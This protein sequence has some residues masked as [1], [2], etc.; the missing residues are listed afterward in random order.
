MVIEFENEKKGLLFYTGTY[1]VEKCNDEVVPIIYLKGRKINLVESN[2]YKKIFYTDYDKKLFE[3]LTEKFGDRAEIKEKIIANKHVIKVTGVDEEIT[4]SIGEYVK[5]RGGKTYEVLFGGVKYFTVKSFR[6]YFYIEEKDLQKFQDLMN[7]FLFSEINPEE[8]P[9]YR[10]KTLPYKAKNGNFIKIVMT[11]PRKISKVRDYL[12]ENGVKTYEADVAFVQRYLIDKS[13]TI[14]KPLPKDIIYYDI[15]VLP[16]G[17]SV[18]D[19]QKAPQPIITIAYY[20]GDGKRGVYILPNDV[21]DEDR[22]KLEEIKILKHFFG[23]IDRK[24]KGRPDHFTTIAGW[25]SLLFDWPYLINRAKRLNYWLTGYVAR[26]LGYHLYETYV[27]TI[28]KI[29]FENAPFKWK[30]AGQRGEDHRYVFYTYSKDDEKI[31]EKYIEEN[32]EDQL[33]DIKSYRAR[34]YDQKIRRIKEDKLYK[35]YHIELPLAVTNVDVMLLYK[36]FVNDKLPTYKLDE[37]A[38][39]EGFEGKVPIDIGKLEEIWKTNPELLIEYNLHDS[40]LVYKIDEK[41]GLIRQLYSLSEVTS[42]IT[43]HV[44]T[45]KTPVSAKQLIDALLLK[46]AKENGIVL[47][48][49]KDRG[50]DDG[51]KY[52]GAYVHDPAKG[53]HQWVG[54]LDFNSLYPTIIRAF[55][56]SPETWVPEGEYDPNMHIKAAN[57]YFLREPI[58]LLVQAVNVLF[59]M[60]MSIKRQLGEYAKKY[61]T[62]STEY[63]ALKAR[64]QAVKGVLNSVY[65]VTGYKK[66]RLYKKEVAEN[67]TTIG[68]MVW[69]KTKE[70]AEELGYKV[71]Y[72]D[73]VAKDSRIIIRRNGKIEVI[74]IEDLFDGEPDH[75]ADDGR[76]YKNLEGVEALTLDENIKVTW[77]PIKYVMRHRTNKKMYRLWL[78]NT[79]HIDVTED[80][81]V[82]VYLNTRKGGPKIIEKTVKN[83]NEKDTL[84]ILNSVPEEKFNTNDTAIKYW[85]LIGLLVGD[86]T[87]NWKGNKYYLQL[88]T[89]NDTQEIIEKVLKPLKKA[90][91]IRNYYIKNNKGD[92]TILSKSLTT[93]M[94][95]FFINENNKKIIPELIDNLPTAYK[96]AFLRGYFTADGTIIARKNG[97]IIRLTTIS[98]DLARRVQEVLFLTGIASTIFRESTPNKYNGKSSGTYSYHV[99]IK[100]KEKFMETIRFILD[101]KND[102]Y[103]RHQKPNKKFKNFKDKDVLPIT[104][105]KIEEIQYKDYVYDI[106]VG[107]TH[108]FFANG[109]LVHNTDSQYYV[110]KSK[111]PEEAVKELEWLAETL[112]KKVQEWVTEEF[113]ARGEYFE[114]DPD[115]IFQVVGFIAKKNYVGYVVY[116]DG[117]ILEEPDLIYAGLLSRGDVSDAVKKFLMDVIDAILLGG[118]DPWEVIEKWKQ[119]V[120]EGK[121]DNDVV[122]WKS[123]NKNPNSYKSIQPHVRAYRMLI[124]RGV[125]PLELT[126]VGFVKVGPRKT[127][128][129]AL[130]PGDTITLSQTQRQYVWKN[131]FEKKIDVIAPILPPK[132]EKKKQRTLF[133]FTSK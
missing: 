76:E 110:L 86:G 79:Q 70:F 91:A 113:G 48:T 26:K 44:H 13:F 28:D 102:T 57:G 30:Y 96:R 31:I 61:G 25:N 41:R 87:W 24:T 16:A 56:I 62:N 111:T 120:L 68:R 63:R 69:H 128:L 52:S 88:S 34:D 53:V 129:I 71:V 126:K 82:F 132:K 18:P 133:D 93:L 116:K 118:R 64:Y 38:K 17:G 20:T 107:G 33:V 108:K 78:T 121:W 36:K 109:I 73:S 119:E 21:E 58:G 81:S 14:M 10:F 89:G 105:K 35:K 37:I 130:A 6:P 59:D 94:R 45:D 83:I 99:N 104:I 74:N 123:L 95:K 65:G 97:T 90:G 106:E 72:G 4:K 19:P 39:L 55:N 50:E 98:P 7:R 3:E 47:P 22:L 66:F 124:Q 75:V 122:I 77:A 125:N 46:I 1:R 131:Q 101:R 51:E 29:E 112:T 27:Y 115:E 43:D 103:Y 54:V 32:Y 85:E 15:E 9:H 5:S 100:D 12:E 2:D 92:V 60:K 117:Q 127:D 84:L 49:G 23:F 114:F 11:D 80:H 67:I 42:A 40:E 8:E